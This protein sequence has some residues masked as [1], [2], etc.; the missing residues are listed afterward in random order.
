SV[1]CST[2]QSTSLRRAAS[3]TSSLRNGVTSATVT[4]ANCSPLVLDMRASAALP[5]VLRS[6]AA[7]AERVL[8][9]Y[10]DR[11]EEQS[12]REVP[13]DG[14]A[15]RETAPMAL[16]SLIHQVEANLLGLGRRLTGDV[17]EERLDECQ[18]LLAE[19]ARQDEALA[20]Q[21][22]RLFEFQRRVKQ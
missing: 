17:R 19:I 9:F 10:D 13:P 21:Q 22:G 14:A 7:L 18:R 20:A 15:L 11:Q 5:R 4:P 3:S 2:C 8:V 1:P 12:R 6:P 16:E